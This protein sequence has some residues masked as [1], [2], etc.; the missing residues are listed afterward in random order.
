MQLAV[1]TPHPVQDQYTRALSCLIKIGMCVPGEKFLTQ[2]LGTLYTLAY[3]LQT[4]CQ[5]RPSPQGLERFA[6]RFRR[7]YEQGVSSNLP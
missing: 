5:L 2:K 4:A 7:L 1:L 3:Y 6:T